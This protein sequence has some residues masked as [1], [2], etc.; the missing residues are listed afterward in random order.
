MM[1]EL[2]LS[3]MAQTFGGTLMYPDCRFQSVSTDSRQIDEGQLFVALR[4]ERFDAHDFLPDVATRA[5]G[6]VVQRPAKDINVPQWVVADT[7]EAL[8]QIAR[9]NREASSAPVI[10][11]TGSSGKTTVKEMVATILRKALGK[12]EGVLATKGNLNN[13][14]GVPLTLLGLGP[15]HRYAVIEMGASA[16][17][18]IRYLCEI[19]RPDVVLVNNV[20]PAHVAGFGSVDNIARAKGE[21]YQGVS[22]QG[23]AVFNLDEPYVRQWRGSSKARS[24][25]FSMV[26]SQADFTAKALVVDESGCYSFVL[27]T[28]AGEASVQLALGGEHNVANALAAAACAYAA[29]VE[30]GAIVAGLNQLAP[31]PGRLNTRRLPSGAMLIDDTYNANPGSV[32]AAINT[33]VT[34]PGRHILVLG[35][36]GELGDDEARLHQEIGRYAADKGVDTLMAVGPLSLN[37]VREFGEGAEHFDSKALLAAQL[38]TLLDK[39]AVVLFKGSRFMAMEDVVR[40]INE[41]G[42]Q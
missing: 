3:Q 24:L 32:K 14:I 21:I 17:G 12:E 10:A 30:F 15:Q 11:I 25:T 1:T 34:I 7:T 6:M 8:G 2:S 36:M 29:G 28:P 26:D 19:A 38:K 16:V 4:G 31:V 5:S 20:L 9:A 39:E 42:E 27:V 33:L 22:A 18:E 41:S 23:V 37:T 13:Q 35:D 40:L